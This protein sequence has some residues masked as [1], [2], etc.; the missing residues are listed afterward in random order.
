MLILYVAL[1]YDYG[2]RRRGYSFE[3]YNFYDPLVRMGHD[4]LYFDVASQVAEKGRV[5]TNNLLLDIVK[6]QR[7]DVLFSVMFREELDKRKIREVSD[8]TDTKTIA[9]FSDDHWRF[10]TYS[11]L[12]AP[13]FNWAVTTSAGALTKYQA[14]G[15]RNIL[16]SQWAC[17]TSIYR[18]MDIPK[19]LPVSFVGVPHGNRRYVIQQL[20]DAGIEVHTFGK[21]WDN[22]RVTQ[23]DMIRI[24]NESC[25]N[26]NLS[27]ASAAR[28]PV[29]R[30]LALALRV[31]AEIPIYK[32]PR[33]RLIRTLNALDQRLQGS[34]SHSYPEQIKGRNFEVPG[35]GGFLLSSHAENL[36]DFYVLDGEV[37]VYRNPQ[38]L[39]GQV[40]RFLRD[41]ERRAE[42][43][44]AGYRRTLREHTWLHRFWTI[45]SQIG[46]PCCSPDA[47]LG[48]TVSAGHTVEIR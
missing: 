44:N 45:F 41:P 10:D 6:S 46:L 8:N 4:V 2:E 5:A 21:G 34:A 28:T 14:L 12:W 22:G 35:C 25:I 29:A 31:L 13:Q 37:A 19:R 15:Y 20:S 9:W 43:A 30:V 27:N 38:D 18:R 42:I 26:L 23:D 7:P 16:K 33:A 36:E 17:N 47:V 32:K 48:G 39:V 40:R 11:R 3:H 24:F 1:K